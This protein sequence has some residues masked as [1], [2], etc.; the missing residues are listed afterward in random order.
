MKKTLARRRRTSSRWLTLCRCDWRCWPAAAIERALRVHALAGWTERRRRTMH[1]AGATRA[2]PGATAA[3]GA[4]GRA[5][6][7]IGTIVRVGTAR[8]KVES[9]RRKSV[10]EEFGRFS[11]RDR[12]SGGM[13]TAAQAASDGQEHDLAH[14]LREFLCQAS[15]HDDVHDLSGVPRRQTSTLTG[16]VASLRIYYVRNTG[17]HVIRLGGTYPTGR[18]SSPTGPARRSPCPDRPTCTCRRSSA[19][20]SRRRAAPPSRRRC[21][22]RCRPGPRWRRGR[23]RSRS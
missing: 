13:R 8:C 17:R 23:R 5:I 15:V 12:S 21:D 10:T 22:R 3:T 7:R 6:E 9:W 19:R 11:T 1:L 16:R 2:P 4:S 18:R 20:R 14:R